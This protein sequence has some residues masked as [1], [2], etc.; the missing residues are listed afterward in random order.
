MS[1]QVENMLRVSPPPEVVRYGLLWNRGIREQGV[2][3]PPSWQESL[4]ERVLGLLL[5]GFVLEGC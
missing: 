2:G 4:S 5:F 3:G 1:L